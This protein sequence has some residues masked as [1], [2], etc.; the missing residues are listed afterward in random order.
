MKDHNQPIKNIL[1]G[2]SSP[3]PGE[4]LSSWLVRLAIAHGLKLHTFCSLL[5]EKRSIWNRDIDRC[6]D[7]RMLTVLAERTGTPLECVRAATLTA[8]EGILYE[9]HNAQGNTF[10]IMPLGVYHRVRRMHGTQYCPGCLT[11][12]NEPYFRRKWRLAFVTVCAKHRCA[13][14]DACPRCDAPVNFHRDELGERSKQVATGMAWCFNCRFDLRA[15]ESV[16]P[17]DICGNSFVYQNSLTQSISDGWN[18]IGKGQM[19]YS[20]LYFPVLRQLMKVLAT[21]RG[22]RLLVALCR[23]TGAAP[24]TPIFPKGRT[25]IESLRIS[26]RHRLKSLAGYLLSGW[27]D[28]FVKICMA[29]RVWSSTLLRDFEFAPFWYWSV[30]RNYL[31]RRSYCAAD[32][33]VAAAIAHI[34]MSGGITYQ[35]AVSEL[36]GTQNVFRKRKSFSDF[37]YAKVGRTRIKVVQTK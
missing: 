26:E 30:V 35:K 1:P 2:R 14:L 24:F 10:W 31:Y 4:L 19:V 9:R 29:E 18:E 37:S 8:Y 11:E 15:A 28:R 16:A 17:P 32:A 5:F 21:H 36:L 13:L 27:P 3:R 33:E 12:G 22:G 34:D 7:D 25:D 20:V 6:A 23:E